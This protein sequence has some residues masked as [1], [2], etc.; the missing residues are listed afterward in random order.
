MHT[1]HRREIVEHVSS[2]AKELYLRFQMRTKNYLL[3][4][5]E[6]EVATSFEL[7]F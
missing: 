3:S 6:K 4:N 2:V 5:S 1:I 7:L